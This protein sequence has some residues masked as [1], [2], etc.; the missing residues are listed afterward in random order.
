MQIE[1]IIPPAFSSGGAADQRTRG[2]GSTGDAYL[3]DGLPARLGRHAAITVSD[4]KSV[5]TGA[6]AE[7]IPRLEVLNAAIAATVAGAIRSGAAP[8]VT[9]GS[10]VSLPGVLGGLQQG[11]GPTARIGLIWFDAHGDFNTPKTS[12]S[13]MLGGMPVAVSAGLCYPTWREAAGLVAPIPTDRIVMVDVRNLDPAERTLIEATDIRIVAVPDRTAETSPF[14]A[15]VADLAATVDHIYL[16][17]D[18][19]VLDAR[20]QPNHPTVEPDGPSLEDVNAALDAVLATGK[21]RAFGVV[22]VNPNGPDG[23]TSLASGMAMIESAV[24]TWG[25]VE[26]LPARQVH[27]PEPAIAGALPDRPR[28]II[29][30]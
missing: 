22:A 3:A 12:Q 16:H 10:C 21:V 8:V 7:P 23:P 25:N 2:L 30:A 14:A 13:Q 6:P 20:Y 29:P 15:A 1:L 18:A 4:L 19:D 26:A 28:P 5:A 27:P 24:A 11:Y 9:G 17:V